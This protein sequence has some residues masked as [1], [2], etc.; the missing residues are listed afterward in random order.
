MN[1][2]CNNVC[3]IQTPTQI[4]DMCMV[5]T[6]GTV[7]WELKGKKPNMLFGFILNG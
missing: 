2:H 7:A 5:Q 3:L 6:D 4:T 1:L